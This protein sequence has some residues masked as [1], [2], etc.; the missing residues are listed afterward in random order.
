MICYDVKIFIG[1][2]REEHRIRLSQGGDFYYADGKWSDYRPSFSFRNHL[3]G[4]GNWS[5]RSLVETA[6]KGVVGSEVEVH[7]D[8]YRGPRGV[9][10]AACLIE[11]HERELPR[12]TP[13]NRN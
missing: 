7:L 6:I 2:D 8:N 13:E 3:L 10:H 12:I 11:V 4:N 5:S 1:P 9:L